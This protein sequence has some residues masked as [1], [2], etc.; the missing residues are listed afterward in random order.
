[1]KPTALEVATLSVF[2]GTWLACALTLVLSWAG[3]LP[4]KRGRTARFRPRLLAA[5]L[6][7]FTGAGLAQVAQDWNWPRDVQ[8]CLD[9]VSVLLSLM[10]VAVAISERRRVGAK[11]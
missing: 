6:A 3:R 2:A 11:P 1:V 4:L 9:L 5:L 10:L 7:M 8:L